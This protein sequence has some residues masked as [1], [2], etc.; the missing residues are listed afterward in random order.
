MAWFRRG[1][2][3]PA[4]PDA[5]KAALRDGLVLLL[6]YL[7]SELSPARAHRVERLIDRLGRFPVPSG[8]VREV[9]NIRGELLLKE[10]RAPD[11][12]TIDGREVG[13][14][15][16]ALSGLALD[17]ALIHSGLEERLL[18]FKA[19]L[20]RRMASN[21]LPNVIDEA[22]A[23]SEAASG[24]R[25]RAQRDREEMSKMLRDMGRRLQ[26]ADSDSARLGDG[27]SHVAHALVHEPAPEELAEVRKAMVAQ[28][29][30]L[31]HD[32]G[33][34][35]Q[36]L[37]E[38]HNRSRSLEDVIARQAE[39]LVDVR[40]RAAL[41]PLTG[42]CN[43]GTFDRALKQAIQRAH[44][45]DAPLSLVLFDIDHFKMVNDTFGHPAGDAVLVAFAAAIRHQV[46]DDDVVGRYG[47]EE[48]AVILPGA[49]ESV[50]MSVAERVRVATSQ[51][52]FPEPAQRVRVTVSAG[53]SLLRES[54]SP[55]AVLR[56]AD[57]ALYA[58][59]HAGRNQVRLAAA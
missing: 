15:V 2:N 39:E 54:D 31:T 18:N 27:I 50:A 19:G 47:G 37:E 29:E 46:R 30:Q 34:L 9:R 43:R 36:Q 25:R 11:P 7:R 21:D 6:K 26:R 51:L 10:Q 5:E 33:S 59:K 35:R 4:S 14:V 56:R 40:A 38:A 32:A 45:A 12:H 49:A 8:L 1:D 23:I 44:N 57:A 16:Q 53:V 42:V 28:L 24:M 22:G 55:K 3:P 13:R 58:A 41:D 20:P 52:R 48:F 17:T